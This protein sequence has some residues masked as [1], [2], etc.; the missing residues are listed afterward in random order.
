MQVVTGTMPQATASAKLRA[1]MPA[2]KDTGSSKPTSSRKRCIRFIEITCS[3][4]PD[5][6]M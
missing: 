1:S 2:E 6:Y 5:R 4:G 3:G